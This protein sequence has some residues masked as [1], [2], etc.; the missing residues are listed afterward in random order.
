VT[1]PLLLYLITSFPNPNLPW[2][3]K[4]LSRYNGF[5]KSPNIGAHL[6]T[7][8][9]GLIWFLR[10]CLIT[11]WK[12][13]DISI[14]SSA[15]YVTLRKYISHPS[16]VMYCFATS[17][18]KLKWGQQTGGGLIA[19]HLEQ[20]LWWANQKHRA[21][22][23]SY[24]LHSFLQGHSADAPFTS[25]ANMRSAK[26]IFLGQT[27]YVGYSS[28]NF[29]VQDHIP[30]TV[31]DALL[32]YYFGPCTTERILKFL[33]LNTDCHASLLMLLLLVFNYPSCN[34]S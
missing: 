8:L 4:G 14:S 21:A 5:L 9:K 17:P 13:K 25:H 6:N 10:S 7:D 20:S 12:K 15:Q 31:G 19:N 11:Y 29:T 24:L 30:S 34:S 16:L 33:I 23:R 27:A 26:T 28:S 1:Y 32:K 2:K 18:I 3:P 22:V